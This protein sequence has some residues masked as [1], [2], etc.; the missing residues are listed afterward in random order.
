MLVALECFYDRKLVCPSPW[1]FVARWGQFKEYHIMIARNCET[2]HIAPPIASIMREVCLVF[3]RT[4]RHC[5]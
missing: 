1:E 5:E 2:I 3:C 4:F